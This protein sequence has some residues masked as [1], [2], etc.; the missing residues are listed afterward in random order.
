MQSSFCILMTFVDTKLLLVNVDV[1][2]E[3]PASSC[4]FPA[5]N[6]SDGCE[7]FPVTVIV[8]LPLSADCTLGM[9]SVCKK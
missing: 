9:D 1:P 2:I 8:Y 7:S 3:K 4:K 5:P 6:V